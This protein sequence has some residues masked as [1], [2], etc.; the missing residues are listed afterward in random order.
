[1]TK[2]CL[3]VA[4]LS[5]EETRTLAS[6][7]ARFVRPGDVV[8]L[9]G[10]LGAG[11]TTFTQGLARGLGI[12]EPVTSPTFTLVRRYGEPGR[13]GLVHADVYRLDFLQEVI[14]LGLYELLEDQVVAVIEWGQVAASAIVPDHLDVRIEFGEAETERVLWFEPV[15]RWVARAAELHRVFGMTEQP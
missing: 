8:L 10:D 9:G 5:A 13:L 14:D 7:L 12:D 15:G 6:R 1:M 4:S 3:G 2:A 11:K